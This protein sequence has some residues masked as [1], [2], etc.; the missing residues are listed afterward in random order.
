[1]YHRAIG[2]RTAARRAGRALA[3]SLALA[4]MGM[5]AAM[6]AS[7]APAAAAAA[8]RVTQSQ[9]SIAITHMT[10]QEAGPGSMIT[11][12]G[13]VTN[14]TRQP[15]S[16][17][18]VR[19]FASSTAVSTSADLRAGNSSAPYALASTP[20]RQGT[21][22]T[23]SELQPGGT[24][25]WSIL[26]KANSIGMTRF[27]VYPLTAYA[28]TTPVQTTP[29]ELAATTTYLPYVPARKG[30]YGS[31]IPARTKIA[32]VMP[33][34]DKPLLGQPWQS[35]CQGPQAR[36]LAASL[37]GGGRLGQLLGAGRDS[38]GTA[39]AYSAAASSGRSA[40]NGAVRS[41]QA[42]SLS[43]YDGVTWAVDPALLAN[44]KALA[45]C[46][47]SQPRWAS[48][49][50]SWLTELRQVTA[51]EPM[52]LTPYA[53]PDVAALV[54][55]GF[56]GDVQASFALGRKIGQQILRRTPGSLTATARSSGAQNQDAGIA[57][58]ADGISGYPTAEFLAAQEGT[59]TLLLS[60]GAL[61]REPAT[62]VRVTNGGGGYTNVLLANA[63]L[64][65]LL[66]AGRSST[67][68]AFAT[69]QDFLAQTALAAQQDHGA[70]LVVAPPQRFDP[71]NGLTADLLAETAL[72]PWVTPVSLTSL[73]AGNHI[74]AVPWSAFTG[75][76]ARISKHELRKLHRV[77]RGIAQLTAMAA[78]PNQKLPLAVATIESSAWQGKSKKAP[79]A[80]LATVLSK[81]DEQERGVQIIAE[82]RVTLGGLK[83][84]VPV[85]IDN[86]L[87]YAVKVALH[88]HSQS[89]SVKVNPFPSGPVTVPAHNALT[90]KLRVQATQVGSTTITMSLL[91]QDNQPLPHAQAQSMSVHATQVG[92]LFVIICAAV[93]GLLLIAYA[94]RAAR[95]GHSAGGADLPADP[96]PAADQGR[97]HSTELAEPDTVMAER[98]ELGTA[99]AP[100]PWRQEA[101]DHRGA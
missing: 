33:L 72:A 45:D 13:T 54:S 31:S 15:I 27:G 86:R 32:W 36:A 20:V 92:V 25:N 61:R 65:G 37:R 48:A 44:V 56:V 11:V 71:A 35:S 46:G 98:T 14:S 81:I 2:G 52:F 30:P 85:S 24:A 41:E 10:P 69:A 7:Q 42:Q 43:A 75:S 82:P 50:R 74:P 8:K 58:P 38:T 79:Q 53:D 34:I 23:S 90:V 73:T 77:D 9:V 97:D 57:W 51:A 95:R 17:L 49:A 70:P 60:S 18:S 26:V 55:K 47:S 100:G 96:S 5:P 89:P 16:N 76:P 88:L 1:M 62:V 4:A 39:D 68:G 80:M 83:G 3:A 6:L 101:D 40:R 78:A 64:T 93:L 99:G 87:G 63:S 29:T 59:Q 21:W 67:G 12:T 22:K 91:N 28:Q 66:S 84:S 94:A 19:L